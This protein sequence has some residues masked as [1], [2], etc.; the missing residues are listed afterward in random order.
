MGSTVSVCQ[1]DEG[2]DYVKAIVTV[3]G[4]GFAKDQINVQGHIYLRNLT[5]SGA[6][7]TCL[8][9]RKV[10]LS[11]ALLTFSTVPLSRALLT[12]IIVSLSRALLTFGTVP[13]VEGPAHL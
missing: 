8:T 11:R 7:C 13:S 12:F 9:S 1:K 3:K 2:A 6:L 10:P 4:P 5:V